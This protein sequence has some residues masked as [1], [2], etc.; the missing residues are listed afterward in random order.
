MK[1]P[2]HTFIHGR[3]SQNKV[4]IVKFDIIYVFGDIVRYYANVYNTRVEEFYFANR[5]RLLCTPLIVQ[6]YYIVE[7]AQ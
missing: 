3:A 6:L 7:L 2:S 5:H 4:D 1:R